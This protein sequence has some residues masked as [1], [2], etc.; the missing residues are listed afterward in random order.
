VP[1]KK[2]L[3]LLATLAT[4]AALVVGVPP[5]ARAD[6]SYRSLT[7]KEKADAF[8]AEGGRRYRNRRVHLHVPASKLLG[9]GERVLRQRGGA[10]LLF[11]HRTVPLV[12]NPQSV[13][14]RKM[15]QRARPGGNVCVKGCVLPD[16]RGGSGR[17]ALWVNTLK[18]AP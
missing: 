12:V 6:V 16:P 14:F 10:V 5:D 11:D 2:L 13:Y 18:R 9:K 7:T 17:L 3:P 1:A 4:L 15:R 8:Y